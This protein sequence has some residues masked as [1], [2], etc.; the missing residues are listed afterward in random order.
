MPPTAHFDGLSPEPVEA[1]A[2]ATHQSPRPTAIDRYSAISDRSVHSITSAL[3]RTA[4]SFTR[5]A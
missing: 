1:S 2:V 5:N 3:L 4:F